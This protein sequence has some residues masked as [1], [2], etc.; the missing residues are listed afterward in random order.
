MQK[1]KGEK[2]MKTNAQSRVDYSG[3]VSPPSPERRVERERERK[4]E[5]MR[6]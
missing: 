3:G 4:R 6:R 2:E 1:S 5:I